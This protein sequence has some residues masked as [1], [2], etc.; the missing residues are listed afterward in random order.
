MRKTLVLLLLLGALGYGGYRYWRPAP[1]TTET[2]ML[3]LYGNVDIR[4]VK[5]AFKDAERIRAVFVEEGDAVSQGQVLAELETHRLRKSIEATRASMRAQE[6]VVQRLKN[7][8]RPEEISASRAKVDQLRAELTLAE[9]TLRR[10]HQLLR[11]GATTQQE[12]DDSQA[13]HDVATERLVAAR[14]ELKLLEAGPR[15]EEIS[16]AEAKLAMLQAE[17]AQ[18]EV[19]LEDSVLRA[20][21]DA[22]VRNRNLEPG[23]MA[24]SQRPVFSLAIET[25]KWI[26]TYVSETDLGRI[27]PGTPGY[28][29]ID[30]K[31]GVRFPGS[32]GFISPVAE[33]TPR[34]V[35][36]PELRTSLVYEVRFN[37][38]DPD[39]SL[40]LG[41]PAT[42]VLDPG[43]GE[44]RE[45]ALP[46]AESPENPS[47]GNGR[48]Q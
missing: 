45:N 40:R 19:V 37:V 41:M 21:R 28:A 31:P 2:G 7:G 46:E 5:L 20:P 48:E 16:E 26:R 22:T 14:E 44:S 6:F 23:D 29:T 4:E 27:R 47:Q 1:D 35:E 8:S 17:L 15:W 13:S 30:A 32:V 12:V 11:T 38:A 42:V 39:N 34:P 10:Q 33:F 18:L 24:S 43:G 25:P 36:T 9:R 3:T